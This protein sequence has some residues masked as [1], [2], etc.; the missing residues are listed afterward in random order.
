MEKDVKA[1]MDCPVILQHAHPGDRQRRELH[2]QDVLWDRRLQEH[3]EVHTHRCSN[4]WHLCR[5]GNFFHC[6]KGSSLGLMDL[7]SVCSFAQKATAKGVT[8]VRVVVK[9]LGPGR[10]VSTRES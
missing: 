10:L 4:G 3:Q 2:G 8:F 6:I 7:T 5:C 9:G 1:F